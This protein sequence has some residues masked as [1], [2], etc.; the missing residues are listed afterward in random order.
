MYSTGIW[1]LKTSR[2][3]ENAISYI[4][5]DVL[6]ASLQNGVCDLSIQGDHQIR[7]GP[8]KNENLGLVKRVVP[9]TATLVLSQSTEIKSGY[10]L[11]SK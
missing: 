8:L 7:Q 5:F 10:N 1:I 6:R 2:L 11:D 3:D 9:S 4:P